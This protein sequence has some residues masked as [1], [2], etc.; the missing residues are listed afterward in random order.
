MLMM[1]SWLFFLFVFPTLSA[2]RSLHLLVEAASSP[3]A[4]SASRLS[5]VRAT[6]VAAAAV[7]VIE[8]SFRLP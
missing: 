6:D 1:P 8:G 7:L 5:F 2:L 4:V 3:T